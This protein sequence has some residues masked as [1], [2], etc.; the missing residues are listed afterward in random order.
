[1]GDLSY[2][3]SGAYFESCNCEAICPC[4][5]IGS[6]LG[7]R[8]TY[9]QC[10]GVLSWAI[11]SGSIDGIEVGGLSVALVYRYDDDEHGSPWSLVLHVDEDAD[12]KQRAALKWLFLDGLHQLPWIRKARHLI[13]VRESAIRIAGTDIWI[14]KTVAVRA[15]RR[16]ET[17]LPVACGVPGYD[18]VGYEMIADE[19][20][21]DDE[22]FAWELQGTCAYASDFDYAST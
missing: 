20:R 10:Y 17:D 1:M 8:P 18:R 4:R 2:R 15:S 7:S 11:E 5:K 3:V 16:V 19:L 12:R 22:P 13:G 21:V 9:G 14:G 6:V